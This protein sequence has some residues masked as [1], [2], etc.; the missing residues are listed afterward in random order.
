[1]KTLVFFVAIALAGSATAQKRLETTFKVEGLCGMCEERI[2]AALD[3]KGVV[4]AEWDA[5][6][7][8][9]RV[10]YK[11]AVITEAQIHATVAEAG[12]DTEQ[13]KA[14]DAA[15]AG[16]HGCCKYRDNAG[17]TGGDH[18]H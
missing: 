17:C 5:H 2:E 15:Y 8:M 12:H 11:P 6:S 1:M 3:V 7:R 9:L 16:L 10:V 13:V 18:T 4:L 14:S